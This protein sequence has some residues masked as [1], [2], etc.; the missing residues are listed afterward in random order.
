M[1][2][3]IKQNVGTV[4]VPDTVES[5]VALEYSFVEALVKLD[6]N[7]TGIADDNNVD[8]LDSETRKNVGSYQ[9]VGHRQT[10]SVDDIKNA[11]T[12]VIFADEDRH[13]SIF[14]DLNSIAPT[15]L[16]KSFD[17]DYKQNKESF[18]YIAKV[19][20]KQDEGKTILDNHEKEIKDLSSK[21]RID[22]DVATIAGVV[23]DQDLII[24]ASKSYVGQL[25]EDVGFKA[26]ISKENENDLP[27][28]MGA[29]YHKLPIS[30]VAEVNP[31]RLI[32]M[33]DEDNQK[34]FNNFKES[35]VWNQLDAVKNNRVHEVNRETWAKHRGLVAA[36]QILED[37][38]QFTE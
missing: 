18:D 33:V 2:K 21:V 36:E 17:A 20:S 12:Q 7:V 28:Y 16:V 5:A 15:V 1:T 9:S 14:E 23:T 11:E 4:E 34:D 19:V 27:G 13:K 6:V 22:K 8:N 25:L 31:E 29:D 32:V 35:D 38:T 24:H 37:I 10:P 3:E 30:K 26:G